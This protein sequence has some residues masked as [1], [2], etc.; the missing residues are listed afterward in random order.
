M[1][2]HNQSVLEHGDPV[3]IVTRGNFAG[4]VS[5]HFVGHVERYDLSAIRVAGYAFV[6]DREHDRFVKR[7]QQR[8]RIFRLDNQIVL[9]VLPSD[10]DV[11]AIRYEVDSEYG[12]TVTDGRHVKLQLS[13]FQIEQ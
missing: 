2:S 4:D 7:K 12:L 8:T 1:S 9:F 11:G 6:H 5:R 3:L 13:E 10:T